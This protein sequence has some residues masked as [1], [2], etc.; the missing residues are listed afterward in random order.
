MVVP[1]QRGLREN[2]NCFH[3]TVCL[4]S[5]LVSAF[6]LL[7]SSVDTE[8]RFFTLSK[9]NEDQQ[10]SETPQPSALAPASQSEELLFRSL[11][12]GKTAIVGLHSPYYGS[13]SNS[14]HF[15]IGFHY[16]CSVSLENPNTYST[17]DFSWLALVTPPLCYCRNKK[18]SSYCFL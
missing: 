6:I 2:Q 9:P 18:V 12:S 17:K 13:Q 4:C 16:V 1:V 15:V 10:L 7:L 3:L 14:S 11:S 8:P 5:F